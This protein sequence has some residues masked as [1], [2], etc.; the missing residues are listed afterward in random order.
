M[1][2]AFFHIRDGQIVNQRTV[3]KAFELPDGGYELKIVKKNRRSLSQNAYYWSAV[4]P[5][6]REGLQD[7]GHDLTLEETHDFLK[8]RFNAK[9]IIN[10]DTGEVISVPRSTTELNKTQFG[11]YIEKIQQF[12]IEYLGVNIPSPNEQVKIFN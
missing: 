6:V 12:S 10:T 7:L 3:R 8:G 1:K 2:T 9:E 5:L 11:E 4:V